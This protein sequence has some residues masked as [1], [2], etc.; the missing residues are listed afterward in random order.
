MFKKIAWILLIPIILFIVLISIIYTKQDQ[1]IQSQLSEMNKGH[2]GLLKIGDTHLAL[3]E[4]FPNIS[5]KIDDVKVYE[6][7]ND[8][9]K[10]ILNVADIFIRFNIIDIIKGNYDI[11]SILLENGTFNIVIHEDG[12]T[13]LEHALATTESSERNQ[14][15]KIHLK[16][17]DLLNL[18]IH[19]FDES[20][21]VDVETYIYAANGG[22]KTENGLINAHLDTE[23]KLNIFNNGDTTYIHDK[24]FEF[25]TDMT[26]N[27][28]TGI[29]DFK[30]SGVTMEHGDFELEGSLDMK[31]DMDLDMTVKGTKP[32]FDMLI[33]FA[34]HEIIPVLERYK[35]AGKIYLNA[36]IQGPTAH[37][38]TPFI[39]AKFGAN[40]AFLENTEKKKRIDN[41]GFEGHFTNGEERNLKTMEFSLNNMTANL[42]KGKFIGAVSVKNFEEPEIDMTLDANF[43]VDFIADFLNLK[44]IKDPS[45]NVNIKMKF[46]DI[47]DLENPE[48]TLKDL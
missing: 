18:D 8:Q 21:N 35:N 34:P 17:I 5:F 3:F 41:M 12:S 11:Q 10:A 42:E 37:G 30:P 39:D 29:I 2:Q 7:K 26:L 31:N 44:D 48:H 38:L 1:V 36:K 16:T 28:K 27:E 15:L 40:E 47:I 23:F 9:E 46:H 45:G 22:F 19:K 6:T 4:N 24:Y 33:A 43:K 20:T 14:S 25:H 32:N 13:N